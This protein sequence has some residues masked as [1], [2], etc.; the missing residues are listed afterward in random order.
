MAATRALEHMPLYFI[1]NRGQLDSRVADHIQ[2]RD[3]TLYF[4]AEGMTLALTGQKRGERAKGKLE[5]L[6]L[7]HHAAQALTGTE[8]ADVSAA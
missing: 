7:G 1:E 8:P 3:T 4:T 6:S 5:R 2:C